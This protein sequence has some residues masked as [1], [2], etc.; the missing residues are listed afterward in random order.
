M[1]SDR[2]RFLHLVYKKKN[3][4]E[5]TVRNKKY[6]T[7]YSNRIINYNASFEN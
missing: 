5:V 7:Y 4:N 6:S 2:Y 3:N 1:N